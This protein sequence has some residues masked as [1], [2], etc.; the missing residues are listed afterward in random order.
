[1]LFAR[2][3]F[4]CFLKNLVGT[5]LLQLVQRFAG[6]AGGNVVWQTVRLVQLVSI[7]RFRLRNTPDRHSVLLSLDQYNT[8]I[9]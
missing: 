7:E 4:S 9:K 8:R 6:S 3:L 5:I 2:H 1:M